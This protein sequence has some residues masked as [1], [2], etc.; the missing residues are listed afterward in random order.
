[1]VRGIRW[2]AHVHP[3][4]PFPVTPTPMPHMLTPL[5]LIL[6]DKPVVSWS[7]LLAATFLACIHLQISKCMHVR[8]QEASQLSN[9]RSVE[10]FWS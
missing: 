4:A 2:A 3:A 5:N 8:T 6:R 1:M 7:R 9:P 10:L